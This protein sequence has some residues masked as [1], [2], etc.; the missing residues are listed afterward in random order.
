MKGR[1]SRGEEREDEGGKMEIGGFCHKI[2]APGYT[3]LKC[4]YVLIKFMIII[5]I[6]KIIF[7]SSFVLILS[8][9]SVL[10]TC[11]MWRE[12]VGSV[13]YTLRVRAQ[14]SPQDIYD[15]TL[16]AVGQ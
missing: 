8:Y 16:C 9:I 13:I 6:H 12:S 2:R 14:L 5:T 7:F 4:S 1:E 15:Y 10:S 3:D 11:G